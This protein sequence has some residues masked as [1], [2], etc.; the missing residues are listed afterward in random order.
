MK[1]LGRPALRWGDGDAVDLPK[2]AFAV[3]ARLILNWAKCESSRAELGTFLWPELDAVRQQ[4]GLRTL[5]TRIRRGLR[6]YSSSP[7]RIDDDGVALDLE[8]VDCDLVGVLVRLRRGGAADV[9]AAIEA[10]KEDLL[11]G[12]DGAQTVD[13]AWIA[14]QRASLRRL[15][16]RVATT[17]IERGDLDGQPRVREAVALGIQDGEPND[18]DVRR[19]LDKLRRS[20]GASK[21]LRA[22]FDEPANDFGAG[23]DPSGP[24]AANVPRPEVGPDPRSQERIGAPRLAGDRI[25]NCRPC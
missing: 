4:A 12:L 17:V 14:E 22:S 20:R 15:F 9:V 24:S 6:S 10:L 7:F 1:L 11:E 25:R 16:S 8:V 13:P 2:K 19:A 5:L 3:A 23:V 21:G 18:P